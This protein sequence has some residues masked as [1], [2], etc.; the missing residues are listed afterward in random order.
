MIPHVRERTRAQGCVCFGNGLGINV[1]P[2]V[3]RPVSISVR[4]E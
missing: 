3:A 2:I 1:E 4:W